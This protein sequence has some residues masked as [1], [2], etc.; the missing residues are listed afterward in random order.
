[1]KFSRTFTGV[2]ELDEIQDILE[3]LLSCYDDIDEFFYILH[4]GGNIRPH[5][6]LYVK[7]NDILP[8]NVA[9]EWLN[10]FNFKLG[11]TRSNKIDLIKYVLSITHSNKYSLFDIK[12]KIDLSYFVDMKICPTKK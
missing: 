5:Y 8:L 10:D 12:G 3:G 1:M 7:F 11:I 9:Q 2:F 4:E 6:H